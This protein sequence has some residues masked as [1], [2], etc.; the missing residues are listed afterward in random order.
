MNI[1]KPHP[2]KHLR[3]HASAEMK[4]LCGGGN[5]ARAASWQLDIGECNCKACLKILSTNRGGG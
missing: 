5:S 2:K 4:P 1:T 3:V